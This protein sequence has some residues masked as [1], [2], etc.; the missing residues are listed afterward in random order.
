MSETANNGLMHRSKQHRYSMTSIGARNERCRN[1]ET[2]VR[3]VCKLIASSNR[4]GCSTGVHGGRTP[5]S[6]WRHSLETDGTYLGISDHMREPAVP[7]KRSSFPDR[8]QTRPRGQ[9]YQLPATKIEKRRRHCRHT[10]NTL[11]FGSCKCLFDSSTLSV[12]VTNISI[13]RYARRPC[14]F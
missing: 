8:R 9:F 5:L 3:A 1:G 4:V 14:L 6:F 13:P 2:S 10:I 11:S 7:N 12:S